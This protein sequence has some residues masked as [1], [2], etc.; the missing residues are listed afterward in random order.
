MNENI[1]QS[2]LEQE[3]A[4]LQVINEQNDTEIKEKLPLLS[5]CQQEHDALKDEVEQLKTG[6]SGDDQAYKE[7]QK[8]LKAFDKFR[9]LRKKG[10][11]QLP[12]RFANVRI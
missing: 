12:N 6:Y 10:H 3:I 11:T 5:R 9:L 7:Y 4:R 8:Q 2:Q 1:K